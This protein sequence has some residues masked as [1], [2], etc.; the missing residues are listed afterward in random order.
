MYN[1]SK[2][3]FNEKRESNKA[4]QVIYEEDCDEI[5]PISIFF[6]LTGDKKFI[7]ESNYFE[8]PKGRYSF[9][10]VNPYAVVEGFK[11]HVVIH[12]NEKIM[13][14]K[15][16]VL[17]VVKKMIKKYEIKDSKYS[18]SG[19]AIGYIGYDIIKQYERISD[20]NPDDLQIPDAVM[21]FYK[22]I[23][24]YDNLKHK[25]ICI[26][27]MFPEDEI[28]FEEVQMEIQNM[29]KKIKTNNGLHA[30]KENKSPA[31]IVS[32]FKKEEFCKMVEDAK[33]YIARGDIFQVVLSQRFTADTDENPFNIYRRLRGQN[34]SPY[35]FYIDFG[36]FQITGSS[37]ESLVSVYKNKVITNPI[38][39]TR[40]RGKD[41][42]EDLKLKNE[43]IND[44]KE[45][46]EH[47]MLLDLARNDIGKISK[48]GTVN[49]DKLMKIELYSHVMHIVSEVSGV[50]GGNYDC[51]DALK[52]CIPAGTV[53]GAPKIR[54]MEIIDKLENTRRGCYAG[55]VGYFSFD[56]NMDTCIAIRTLVIKNGK[57]YAQ[58]GGGIV[59]DS[60]PENEYDESLNKSKILRE[61]I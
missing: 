18:F 29:S 12:E 37:P 6:N 10:G 38:A 56:G 17:A 48:F 52:T 7:L 8:S 44:E 35:L 43:L 51:F 23:I 1:I 49:V 9:A 11:N 24:G 53:S 41:E 14:V 16:D 55:A 33:E 34:P 36:E 39:G 47:S 22:K 59:Y 28:S 57:A 54:A 50:L 30:L 3:E 46:A 45:I 5:T 61:V 21:M 40:P 25:V 26:Y 27:N 4:F 31:N 2:K 15:S 19:G 20:N 60:I 13:E 32:N 58:A 42:I